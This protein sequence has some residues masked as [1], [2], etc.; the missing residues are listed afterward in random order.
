MD[1]QLRPEAGPEAWSLRLRPR[2]EALSRFRGE[3]KPE[4]DAL[5]AI[6]TTCESE[7]EEDEPKQ[8]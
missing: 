5:D 6:V 2:T 1:F 3:L 8:G 7:S 4:W